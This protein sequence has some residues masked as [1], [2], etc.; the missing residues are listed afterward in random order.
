MRMEAKHSYFKKI[1]QQGNF[2]NI[3]LSV[4]KRHQKLMCALLNSGDF[5]E[6]SVIISNGMFTSIKYLNCALCILLDLCMPM[7]NCI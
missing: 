1:A 2:K 3:T 7:Y 5:F 6:K 4:S